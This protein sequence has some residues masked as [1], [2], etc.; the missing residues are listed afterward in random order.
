M[1]DQPP[2]PTDKKPRRPAAARKRPG[3]RV[4][5]KKD[6]PEAAAAVENA[7][8]EAAAPVEPT[9]KSADIPAVLDPKPLAEPGTRGDAPATDAAFVQKS[10][11]PVAVASDAPSADAP[12]AAA[13]LPAAAERTDVEPTA[14][15][16][17][18]PAQTPQARAAEATPNAPIQRQASLRPGELIRVP[19]SVRW[20]DLDAFNH[21]NNSK[22]LSYLEEAR[23]RWMLS[24]PGM[25]MDE[26]VAPVVAASNLSYRRP[27]GWPGDIVVEL[28]VERIGGSSLTIGHRIV[29]STDGNVLYCDG[30][31]VMVWIDRNT[32]RSAPL[33][34]DVRAACR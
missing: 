8:S 16:A 33:P 4:A 23:L 3:R 24:V 12:A 19:L 30:N 31:V 14:A 22:Y 2:P 18:K 13:S 32:G 21:V 26:N 34:E 25:G 7:V 20:R 9:A 17:Q 5:A 1:T 27:I 15:P 11:E 28:F 10:P 6:A 29:D